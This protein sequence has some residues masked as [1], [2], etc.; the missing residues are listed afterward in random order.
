ME[1][2]I[3]TAYLILLSIFISYSALT[4]NAQSNPAF[5]SYLANTNLKFQMPAGYNQISTKESFSPTLRKIMS[6]MFSVVENK[7]K[8]IAIGI[9]LIPVRTAFDKNLKGMFPNIDANQSYLNIVKYQADTS[10]FKVQP[11]GD[12]ELK[13]I[14]ADAGFRYQLD[15]NRLFLQKYSLCKVIII[16]K[17]DIGDAEI[18]YFYNPENEELVKKEMSETA[19]ILTFQDISQFK[20]TM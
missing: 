4:A 1:K 12:H 11:L 8:D 3:K 20:P 13:K 17:K 7:Q 19:N 10:T 15:M 14:N 5:D 9:I 18:C 6:L 16:H 2:S